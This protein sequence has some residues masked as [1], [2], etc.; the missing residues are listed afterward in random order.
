MCRICHL[1][2]RSGEGGSELILLGAVA[3]ASSGSRTAT[4]L[5]LVPLPSSRL[6][7]LESGYTD[8]VDS[9][10]S[11]TKIGNLISCISKFFCFVG[12]YLLYKCF[13]YINYLL[14]GC[15][16]CE[17]CGANAKNITIVIDSRVLE[18]G[19]TRRELN[20]QNPYDSGERIVCWRRLRVCKS[21][22]ACL[23]M[24]FLL[25]WFFHVSML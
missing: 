4:V 10:S 18:E 2:S 1:S 11:L 6:W 21:L 17:I 9:R 7:C 22:M 5:R 24:A 12:I 15:R 25:L 14:C 20:T 19:H 8:E 13:A 23:I 16:C 3:R